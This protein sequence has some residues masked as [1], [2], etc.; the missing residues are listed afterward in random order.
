MSVEDRDTGFLFL[1]TDNA[2]SDAVPMELTLAKGVTFDMIEDDD[3][4]VWLATNTSIRVVRRE[5]VDFQNSS[6]E[7]EWPI[8]SCTIC[9][10]TEDHD[11]L[12]NS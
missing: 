6:F 9:L 7:K 4:V 2:P 12:M 10:T 1:D 5:T 3:Q 8:P 11:T